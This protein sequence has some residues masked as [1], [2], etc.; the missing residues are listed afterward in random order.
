MKSL[1]RNVTHQSN[2]NKY[3]YIPGDT[4]SKLNM[5]LKMKKDPCSIVIIDISVLSY[6]MILRMVVSK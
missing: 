3:V 6:L 2:W 1:R 4:A 5:N